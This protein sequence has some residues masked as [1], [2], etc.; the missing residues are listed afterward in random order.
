[1]ADWTKIKQ[2]FSAL[3]AIKVRPPKDTTDDYSNYID[4]LDITQYYIDRKSIEGVLSITDSADERLLAVMEKE[5]DEANNEALATARDLLERITKLVNE[6][7]IID[8]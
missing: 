5:S 1:M 4:C 7:I 6:K 3:R 8:K 2:T